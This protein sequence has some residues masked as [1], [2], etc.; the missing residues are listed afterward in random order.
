MHIK[1][2][3]LK[4]RYLVIAAAIAVTLYCWVPTLRSGEGAEFRG[5]SIAEK[6]VYKTFGEWREY[7]YVIDDFHGIP[8]KK[9]L[10]E[11]IF[12]GVL[13]PFL[14]KQVWSAFGFD[15]DKLLSYNAAS[16]FGDYFNHYTGIRIGIIG[17]CYVGFGVPGLILIMLFL[18][19]VFGYVESRFL[20]IDREDPKL[21]VVCFILSMLLFLPWSSFINFTTVGV[22]FG[23]FVVMSMFLCRTRLQRRRSI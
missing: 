20:A 10:K 11:K 13:A 22:F 12:I 19:L 9:L 16:Y 4:I 3:K 5:L 15:K 2:K 23:V 1:H 17:E 7:I 18:G 8:G 14:P 21:T 6:A